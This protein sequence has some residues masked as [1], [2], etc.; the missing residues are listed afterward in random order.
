MLINDPAVCAWVEGLVAAGRIPLGDVV[1]KSTTEI[2]PDGCRGYTQCHFF[3]GIAGWPVVLPLLGGR[4]TSRS[5]PEA[6][7]A[8]PSAMLDVKKAQKMRAISGPPSTPSSASANLQRCL[9]SKLRRLTEGCG[10]P[11]YALTGSTRLCRWG[12][13]SVRT[14]VGAPHIRQRLYWVANAT[15]ERQSLQLRTRAT[16]DSEIGR[17]GSSSGVVDTQGVRQRQNG[18]ANDGPLQHENEPLQPYRGCGMA[19]WAT[20]RVHD[21]C[22]GTRTLLGAEN[23]A[24]RKGWNNELG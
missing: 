2:S 16:E 12:C 14:G 20:P 8:N 18:C 1:C 7:P 24:K 9:E 13:R 5:G 10:S 6:V 15:D 11:L 22:T 21:G 3:C 19:G 17:S 4:T 23:E